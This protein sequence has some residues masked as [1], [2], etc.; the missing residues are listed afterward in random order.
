MIKKKKRVYKRKVKTE[1]V[2]EPTY[3]FFKGKGWI[4]SLNAYQTAW[5]NVGKYRILVTQ[6]TPE[7]GDNY[8]SEDPVH[9]DPELNKLTSIQ[10][11]MKDLTDEYWTGVL[12]CQTV[13]QIRRQLPVWDNSCPRYERGRDTFVIQLEP[14][15][16]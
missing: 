5:E 13:E 16:G 15:N 2:K 10:R 11:V 12:A 3:E 8:F 6:K 4:P 7:V 1:A 9:Y 14:I